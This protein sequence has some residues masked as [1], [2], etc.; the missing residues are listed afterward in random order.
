MSPVKCTDE[1]LNR[2]C[3]VDQVRPCLNNR[4]IRVTGPNL[5]DIWPRGGSAVDDLKDSRAGAKALHHLG[6]EGGD[7]RKADA[8]VGGVQDERSQVAYRQGVGSDEKSAVI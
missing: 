6:I 5:F 3:R 2:T 7:A 8:D 1:S 4:E